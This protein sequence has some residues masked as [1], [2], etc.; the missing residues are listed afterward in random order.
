MHSSLITKTPFAWCC[1]LRSRLLNRVITQT[2]FPS[3]R[4]DK[5]LW[6]VLRGGYNGP[7]RWDP[8]LRNSCVCEGVSPLVTLS[9]ARIFILVQELKG[10]ELCESQETGN[11]VF[12]RV[13]G[14]NTISYCRGVC[15]GAKLRLSVPSILIRP[16]QPV[17]TFKRSLRFIFHYF[18]GVGYPATQAVH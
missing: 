10:I 5:K 2:E 15:F 14:P 3:Y 11:Y 1:V 12:G 9:F 16:F 13:S 7:R 6:F 18:P 8:L 17:C 4:Y